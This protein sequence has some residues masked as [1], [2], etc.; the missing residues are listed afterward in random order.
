MQGKG[1]IEV[2]QDADLVLVDMSLKKTVMN[3]ELQTRVNWSPYHG[4]ELKGWPV[5]TIVNGQTVFLNGEVDKSVRGRE[6]R[7]A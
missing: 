2:G 5:Q 3:G 1:R 6:I 7:F 4:M